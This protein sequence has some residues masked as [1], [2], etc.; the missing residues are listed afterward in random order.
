MPV[1]PSLKSRERTV[2]D[3]FEKHFIQQL[4][5]IYE[6][7]RFNLRK[8]EAGESVDSFVTA[9]FTLSEHC[10]YGTFRDEMIRDRLVV[11]L[12]DGNLSERLQLKP[13]L[14]LVDAVKRPRNSEAVKAQQVTVRNSD[15]PT[16]PTVSVD[17][18]QA[19]RF[20]TGIQATRN[21]STPEVREMQDNHR[22]DQQQTVHVPPTAHAAGAAT[23]NIHVENVRL[24]AYTA[25]R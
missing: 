23:T 20:S 11:G 21:D 18:M 3:R 7:A 24:D 6:R 25:T 17:A 2:K 8:Q 22:V 1:S 15:T 10:G 13:D 16:H 12:L 19:H 14:T 9:L 5:P 4:N